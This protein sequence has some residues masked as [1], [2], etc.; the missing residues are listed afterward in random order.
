MP[1]PVL[2]QNEDRIRQPFGTEDFN[3]EPGSKEPG[4]LFSNNIS[5]LI[6][7]TT[8]ELFDWFQFGVC[9]KAVLS[10]FPR[11][12][13]HVRRFPCKDVSILTDE[14]DE[15]AFLFVRQADP[16]GELL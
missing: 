14:L 5:S 11:D 16:N 3:D 10:E 9:I 4:Y 15:R 6:V 1:S 8:E 12:T 2:F 13:W 7:E